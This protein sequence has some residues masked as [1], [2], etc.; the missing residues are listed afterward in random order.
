[1][2]KGFIFLDK[3]VNVNQF[4]QALELELVRGNEGKIFFQIVDSDSFDDCAEVYRRVL[5][6][7]TTLEVNV[8]F[9]DI[10]ENFTVERAAAQ[11]FADDKSIWC[12]DVLATDRFAPNS[13]MVS[14]VVDGVEEILVGLGELRFRDTGKRAQ[15]C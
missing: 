6:Q 8:T 12:V 3:V 7:G 13:M 2:N 10:N 15:F 4:D 5:P 9:L 11:P 14:L 1:M